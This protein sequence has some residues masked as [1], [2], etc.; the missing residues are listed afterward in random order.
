MAVI[1]HKR[2]LLRRIL[3]KAD[4]G[5]GTTR[6]RVRAL[7]LLEEVENPMEEEV[8]YGGKSVQD[9]AQGRELRGNSG[10]SCRC[11]IIDTDSGRPM[12]EFFAF[13]IFCYSSCVV[14]FITYVLVYMGAMLCVYHVNYFRSAINRKCPKNRLGRGHPKK[15]RT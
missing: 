8:G 9:H 10:G 3:P 6:M 12:D 14:I 4:P 2:Y 15:I 13:C 5:A 11:V 7:R 1:N